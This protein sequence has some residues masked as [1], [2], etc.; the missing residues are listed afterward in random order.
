MMENPSVRE[1]ALNRWGSDVQVATNKLSDT[2]GY[3]WRRG[4]VD[5]F[6]APPSRSMARFAYTL[7]NATE[8]PPMIK[9]GPAVKLD[10]KQTL[11]IQEKDG[12]VILEFQNFTIRVIPK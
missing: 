11:S 12:E 2:L 4:I 9:Y 8:T 3:M 1:A 5:R 7:K 6:S 10:E